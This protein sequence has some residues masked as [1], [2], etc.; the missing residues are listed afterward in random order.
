MPRRGS[1]ADRLLPV[2]SCLLTFALALS[3]RMFWALP[4]ETEPVAAPMKYSAE[5]Y[6]DDELLARCTRHPSPAP[7]HSRTLFLLGRR[8]TMTRQLLRLRQRRGSTPRPQ[9]RAKVTPCRRLLLRSGERPLNST[10]E[11][12]ARW[13]TA[14]EKVLRA[15][16]HHRWHRGWSP[17]V[18]LRRCLLRWA[19]GD[20]CDADRAVS[21]RAGRGCSYTVGRR[22]TAGGMLPIR[23]HRAPSDAC[24]LPGAAL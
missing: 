16:V 22:P 23:S 1:H 18:Q 17:A 3:V 13:H 8:W 24:M 14:T 12:A 4:P 7:R 21:G 19:H 11:R 5:A 20:S 10:V 15:C 2:A 6:W 9:R